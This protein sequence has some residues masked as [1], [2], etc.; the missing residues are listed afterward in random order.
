[1]TKLRML[2]SISCFPGLVS[3]IKGWLADYSE[4]VWRC[5]C[6]VSDGMYVPLRWLFGH[7]VAWWVSDVL[8]DVFRWLLLE[9]VVFWLAE[10]VIRSRWAA[11]D[12]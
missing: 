4:F 12:R 9:P 7:S 3:M 8:I 5:Y 11:E 1:M 2:G 6:P 10:D